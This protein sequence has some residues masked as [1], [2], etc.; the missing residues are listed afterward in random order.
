M[1]SK[2]KISKNQCGNLV[3]IKYPTII[4]LHF[5]LGQCAWPGTYGY[6]WK[7]CQADLTHALG[8]YFTSKMILGTLGSK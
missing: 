1:P 3:L 5:P 8:L 2:E 4:T 7:Q 6:E